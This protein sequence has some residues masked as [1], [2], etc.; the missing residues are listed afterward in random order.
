MNEDQ[1]TKIILELRHLVAAV[2][3]L[4]FIAI[5]ATFFLIITRD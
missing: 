2:R 3:D 1:A 5:F 4:G